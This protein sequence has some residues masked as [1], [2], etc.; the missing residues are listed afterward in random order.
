MWETT[1]TERSLAM[2]GI[3]ALVGIWGAVAAIS[4][5]APDLISGSEQ[6]HL[7]VAAFTTWIWG[8]VASRTVVTT[9]LRLDGPG[10]DDRLHDQVWACVA[11]LWVIAALVAVFAPPM[12]TGSDPT[13]LPIAAL[14]APMAATALTTGI[15]ELASA[16]AARRTSTTAAPTP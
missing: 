4:L 3:G 6:E 7:P 2:P 12:V 9:L 8:A 11:G 10:A 14:L 1:G 13:R 15:C 5:F 16:V